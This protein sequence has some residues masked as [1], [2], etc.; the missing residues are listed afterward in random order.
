[1]RW[2]KHYSHYSGLHPSLD[3]DHSLISIIGIKVILYSMLNRNN[4]YAPDF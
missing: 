4:W 2:T 3:I 1:M